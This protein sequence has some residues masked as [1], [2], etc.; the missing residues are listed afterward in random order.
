MTNTAPRVLA[1]RFVSA[2][3]LMAAQVA[4]AGLGDWRPGWLLGLA[5]A[6]L[7][8]SV[9]RGLLRMNATERAAA[10]DYLAKRPA[11]RLVSK[12]SSVRRSHGA[13][14]FCYALLWALLSLVLFAEGGVA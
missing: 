1:A 7:L 10:D 4:C 9:G 12:T 13:F 8:T 14:L 3:A 11:L 2:I 6:V 5:V